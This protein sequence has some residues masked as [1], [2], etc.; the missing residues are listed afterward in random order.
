MF[1][2]GWAKEEL[3][4]ACKQESVGIKVEVHGI[5]LYSFGSGERAAITGDIIDIVQSA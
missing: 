5:N 1:W 2:L 3:L 4:H